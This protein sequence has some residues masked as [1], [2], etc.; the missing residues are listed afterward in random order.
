MTERAAGLVFPF[1]IYM[2][3][4][5]AVV[6]P[7]GVVVLAAVGALALMLSPEVQRR[8]AGF[9]GSPLGAALAAL[10]VWAAVASLWSPNPPRSIFLVFRLSLIFAGGLLYVTALE[11]LD[12][13]GRERAVTALVW[14]GVLYLA[15]LGSEMIDGGILSKLVRSMPLDAE[16]DYNRLNRSGV[17]L[18]IF[19]WPYALALWRRAGRWAAMVFLALTLAYLWFVPMM[20]AMVAFMIGAIAFGAALLRARATILVLGAAAVAGMVLGPPLLIT[21]PVTDVLM[22]KIVALSEHLPSQMVSMQHRVQIWQFVLERIAEHPWWGWGFDASR[23]LPG[24][25]TGAI[26]GAPILPLHPHNGVLQIWLEIGLP[27]ALIGAVILFLAVRALLRFA[28]SRRAA[29]VGAAT[30]C[31]WLLV[32]VMSFGIWQNWWLVIAWLAALIT[33]IPMTRELEDASSPAS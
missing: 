4:P 22:G 5:V 29:A 31:T 12:D 19:A 10:L 33:A 2:L 14:S 20:A 27:G 26:A 11:T 1:V 28:G 32:A 6:I 23:A 15:V 9:L 17:I 21:G 16:F 13:K 8:Y 30:F 25:T 18:A 24:G 7:T 3:P